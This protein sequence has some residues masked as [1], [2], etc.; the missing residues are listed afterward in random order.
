MIPWS[1][2]SIVLKIKELEINL[3]SLACSSSD[4]SSNIVSGLIIESITSADTA[5]RLLLLY[6][7][8]FLLFN[9]N[10][11]SSNYSSSCECD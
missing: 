5:S 9:I 7:A 3:N 4:F 2:T 10:S 6:A 11:S 1:S 8:F